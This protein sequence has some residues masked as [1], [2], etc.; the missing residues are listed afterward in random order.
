[1][2]PTPEMDKD[3]IDEEDNE[4]KQ[5][6]VYEDSSFLLTRSGHLYSWGNNDNGF[7]G[8][9]V[10]LDMKSTSAEDRKKHLS[11]STKT[12]GKVEK[13]LNIELKKIKIVDG[14]FMGFLVDEWNHQ[15]SEDDDGDDFG[16]DSEN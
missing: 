4:V 12:P 15:D 11:F 14:K 3:S 1:V 9:E 10:K 5:I 8:R 16:S 2:F 7:L 13:L 6:E